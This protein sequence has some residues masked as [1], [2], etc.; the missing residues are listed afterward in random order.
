MP[1]DA[2]QLTLAKLNSVL[3]GKG[4]EY[5][6]AP[7]QGPV[8]LLPTEVRGKARELGNQGKTAAAVDL[9]LHH[10]QTARIQLPPPLLD[11]IERNVLPQATDQNLRASLGGALA[12][13]R[14]MPAAP[15]GPAGLFAKLFGRK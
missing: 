13:L 6:A 15:A 3:G 10:A 1:L 8:G 5:S 11:E 4:V 9:L 2:A 12:V 14:H 7:Q